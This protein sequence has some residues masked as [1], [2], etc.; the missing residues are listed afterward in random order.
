MEGHVYQ[1]VVRVTDLTKVRNPNRDYEFI[2]EERPPEEKFG[3]R[4]LT[5]KVLTRHMKIYRRDDPENFRTVI[6]AAGWIERL[7]HFLEE[8]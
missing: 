5:D 3:Y 2:S 6:I 4:S 1:I 8:V 7:E